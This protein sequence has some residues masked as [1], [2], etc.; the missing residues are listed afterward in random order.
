[1]FCGECGTQN[2]ETNRFCRNCGKPLKRQQTVT[3]EAT[4]PIAPAQPAVMSPAQAPAGK[5]RRNWAGMGS[6]ITG[7]LSW[8]F[9][10]S[11]FAIL[12]VILGCVS[13]FLVRKNSGKIAISA[14]AGI[15]L[16]LAAIA[17]TFTLR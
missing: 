16:A 8:I 17:V 14:I 6:L 7:I 9:L 10:T 3:R 4:V 1:M 12:A 11:L 13:F 2:P 15:I 5:R